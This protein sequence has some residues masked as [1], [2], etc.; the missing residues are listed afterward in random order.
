MISFFF[1]YFQYGDNFGWGCWTGKTFYSNRNILLCYSYI[2]YFHIQLMV[3][4]N[5]S[6][7]PGI[8]NMWYYIKIKNK[9]KKK[10][11]IKI[12]NPTNLWEYSCSTRHAIWSLLPENPFNHCL[13]CNSHCLNNNFLSSFN[14][15][16]IS[17]CFFFVLMIISFF[18]W[19]KST[20]PLNFIH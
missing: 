7:L 2:L 18:L 17:C 6:R 8:N 1:F 9:T 3:A 16:I 11:K 12:L 19:N 15:I 5:N 4:S 13:L 14:F 10:I 20:C